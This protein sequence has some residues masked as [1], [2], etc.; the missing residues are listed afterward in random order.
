MV[1]RLAFPRNMSRLNVPKFP[2]KAALVRVG[3]PNGG[4][5]E[6]L[7]FLEKAPAPMLVTLSGIITL[8]S[9]LPLKAAPPILVTLFPMVT[10]VRALPAKP[11]AP[12]VVT[13]FGITSVT[14]RGA[15]R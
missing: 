8:V 3:P 15:K 1:A 9:L 11:P 5:S 10:L 7:L 12:R 6:A 14:L 2:K 13:L 4:V